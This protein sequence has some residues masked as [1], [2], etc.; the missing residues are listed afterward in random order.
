[1]K[2]TMSC[3]WTLLACLLALAAPS[4]SDGADPA[5]LLVS[6]IVNREIKV[7]VTAKWPSGPSNVLCEAWAF[8]KENWDF[9]D[10][11]V[12]ILFD[13]QEQHNLETTYQS[14]MQVA[15]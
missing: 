1:M 2:M 7:S 6:P 5:S 12:S 11:L 8:S 10:H 15:L 13:Q 9:L 3:R 14:M 4:R